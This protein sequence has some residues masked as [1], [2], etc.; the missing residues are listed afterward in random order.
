MAT[1]QNPH[2]SAEIAEYNQRLA[3]RLSDRVGISLQ[4]YKVIKALTQLVG[5]AAGVYAMQ[6]GADPM[7]AFALIAFIIGGPELFEYVLT[8]GGEA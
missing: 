4:T 2:L 6:Q 1:T 3:E 8:N 5:A 7:T